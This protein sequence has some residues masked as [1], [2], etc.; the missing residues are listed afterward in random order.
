M[1]KGFHAAGGLP[2][3]GHLK[4]G[5]APLESSLSRFGKLVARWAWGGSGLRRRG[6]ASSV[7]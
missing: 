3:A 2:K 1:L 6:P 4:T 7:P 5:A